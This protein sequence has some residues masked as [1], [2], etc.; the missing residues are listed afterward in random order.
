MIAP[1][2]RWTTDDDTGRTLVQSCPLL[3]LAGRNVLEKMTEPLFLFPQSRARLMPHVLFR[4]P[5]ALPPARLALPPSHR[6]C[7]GRRQK[8]V[9]NM[10]V[11]LAAR[12]GW[13]LG[14]SLACV[15]CRRADA[16]T[17][18]RFAL[19]LQ[20][21]FKE[22]VRGEVELV[23]FAGSDV[24]ARIGVEGSRSAKRSVSGGKGN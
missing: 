24:V 10:G 14:S 23:G 20:P 16:S 8:S 19:R 7:I 15:S 2:P 12:C 3:A 6:D 1:R 13:L 11:G 17:C 21:I 22:W 4:A 18:N 9:V 5:S